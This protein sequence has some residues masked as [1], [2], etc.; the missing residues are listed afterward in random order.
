MSHLLSCD[1]WAAVTRFLRCVSSERALATTCRAARDGVSKVNQIQRA[2]NERLGL[3]KEDRRVAP[4]VHRQARKAYV[5]LHEKLFTPD[6]F[7]TFDKQEGFLHI[8]G[9][10]VTTLP[11]DSLRTIAEHPVDCV[12]MINRLASSNSHRDIAV[13]AGLFAFGCALAEPGREVLVILSSITQVRNAR[14]LVISKDVYSFISLDDEGVLK[15]SNKSKIYLMTPNGWGARLDLLKAIA[16]RATPSAVVFGD[17]PGN[18]AIST[19]ERALALF[20]LE[21]RQVLTRACELSTPCITMCHTTNYKGERIT[22]RF[23]WPPF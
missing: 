13:T 4:T 15:L 3:V 21:M 5:F 10:L 20:V 1:D 9:D 23:T 22:P 6:G 14:D 2:K 19:Q 7:D 17:F 8:T 12:F 11:C 18:T 16:R